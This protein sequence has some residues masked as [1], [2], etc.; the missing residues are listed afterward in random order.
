MG[1]A[2]AKIIPYNSIWNGW[3]P[4]GIYTIPHGFHM[5]CG[6]TVKTSNECMFLIDAVDIVK[7]H[8]D[9]SGTQENCQ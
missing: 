3:N 4:C 1:G 9:S 2:S 7:L 6:G 8:V 5:E